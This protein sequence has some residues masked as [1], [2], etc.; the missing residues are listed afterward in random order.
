MGKDGKEEQQMK[1]TI[2]FVYNADGGLFNTLS[3]IVHK[4]FSPET[5][6]CK[7]CSI[8]Y[9]VLGMKLDVPTFGLEDIEALANLIEERYLSTATEN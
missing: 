7:L 5:Y 2:V 1:D 6:R 3:N 4:I 8:T 9:S